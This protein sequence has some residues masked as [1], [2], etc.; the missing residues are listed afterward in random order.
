[1]A[2]LFLETEPGP[3]A[4]VAYVIAACSPLGILALS[5]ARSIAR[6][7]LDRIQMAS[8]QR[9]IERDPVARGWAKLSHCIYVF[10]L[11]PDPFFA[12][13]LA[14]ESGLAFGDTGIP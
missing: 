11:E 7:F 1:M 9:I 8:L 14:R 6:S 2:Q 10:A 12:M 4:G 13:S 3:E 5:G